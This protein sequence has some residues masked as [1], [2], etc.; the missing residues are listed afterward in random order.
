MSATNTT[1]EATPVRI[2]DS[3][4]D[5]LAGAGVR[6]VF[7]VT[8]GGAMHLNDAFGR[9]PELR[10]TCFHH[11]QAA[12]MAADGYARISGRPAVVNVTSGPGS[13]N[14]I[15]G[16]AGAHFD[17]LP[18]IVISGQMKRATLVRNTGL[19]LCQFGDQE[20]DIIAMVG[21]ITKYAVHVEDPR[22]ARYHVE[23]GLYLAASG[24]PGPVWI[25][26]PIDV[27]A[28]PVVPP[29]QVCYKA[30]ADENA[31]RGSTDVV[32]AVEQILGLLAS[33]A[34]PVLYLGAGVRMAGVER[35]VLQLT[36]RI[37]APVVTSLNAHDLVPHD[38]P[39]LVGHPG[40]IGDRAGNFA[41]QNA[42]PVIVL[43][44][45]LPIRQVGYNWEGW[46]PHAHVVMVD[47][48]AAELAKPS[49]HVETPIH[50]DVGHVVRGLLGAVPATAAVHRGWLDWCLARRERYPVVLAAYRA[51][52]QPINPYVAIE[53][54]FTALPDDAVV[55]A[56][57]GWVGVGAAQA[58]VLRAGHRLYSNSGC[59]AMGHDLPAALGAAVA[60]PGRR[61]V[62]I[63]GDGSIQLNIQEL[64][65]LVHHGWPVTVIVI[66][67]GGYHSIRQ[68][69]ERFFPDGLVGFDARTGIS[70][71]DMG[72]IAASYG[73]PFRSIAKLSE[74]APALRE[75]HAVDGPALCE[76]LVDRDQQFAPKAASRALA[77]GTMVSA[78]LEDLAPF[79]DRDELAENMLPVRRLGPDPGLHGGRVITIDPMVEPAD[80]GSLG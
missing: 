66:N 19:P 44:T 30:G 7:M 26:I 20:V 54:V 32:A 70:F 71:P 25:D 16:V 39:A 77:D 50:A 46:A 35:E 12:A 58:A 73:L 40:I 45:R 59:G 5:T 28:A 29:D 61:V 23:R 78:P 15:T 8:G 27:Q 17:S 41:V 63:A 24:R 10:V 18:M 69:Q 52:E 6:E 43:G 80:T 22:M 76:V 2:A 14:A 38:H 75:L 13:T 51:R 47:I 11:E 67:N 79:L 33:S 53:T 34:R 56:G 74:L 68:T 1:L 4:A 65:T 48:D 9:H 21:G 72:G 62:C 60:A 64:Q 31:Q 49:L 37:G 57:D 3:I 55:I 36:E 42:D